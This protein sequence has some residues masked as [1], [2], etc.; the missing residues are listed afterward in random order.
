[1]TIVAKARDLAGHLAKGAIAAAGDQ[2]VELGG[3]SVT[4]HAP[5]ALAWIS[6]RQINSP[7]VFFEYAR[8]YSYSSPAPARLAASNWIPD[9]QRT[10]VSASSMNEL[11]RLPS[12]SSRPIPNDSLA[13][14]YSRA[15]A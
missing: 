8:S 6:F 12:P 7:T 14:S 2:H 1:V 9:Q 5:R 10:H 11:A 3:N 4:R 15:L 13:L